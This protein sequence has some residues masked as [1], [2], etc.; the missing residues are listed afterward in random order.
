MGPQ[1]FLSAKIVRQFPK[2]KSVFPG[3][4]AF[5]TLNLTRGTDGVCNS[6]RI[7]KTGTNTPVA[8]NIAKKIG[9]MPIQHGRNSEP[10]TLLIVKTE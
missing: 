5:L 6:S 1:H 9:D 3:T 10:V 7:S 8:K 2:K 4:E